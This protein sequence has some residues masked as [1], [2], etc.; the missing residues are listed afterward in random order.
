MTGRSPARDV[1]LAGDRLFCSKPNE[2]VRATGPVVTVKIAALVAVPPGVVTEIVPVVAPVGTVA[3]TEVAVLVEN[4]AAKPLNLTAVTPV[5]LV[6]VMVTLCPTCPVVGENDVI[7]G[8][9]ATVKAKALVAGPP[10]VVVT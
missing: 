3:V 6:P 7:V 4:V 9:P 1:D 8:T 10:P 2:T 5:R